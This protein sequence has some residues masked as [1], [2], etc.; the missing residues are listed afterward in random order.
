MVDPGWREVL[1]PVL[2]V[3]QDIN[4]RLFGRE[5]LPE[6]KHVLRVF[7]QPFADV[8]VLLIGQDPYPKPGLAVGLSFSVA[9]DTVPLPPSLQRLLA[10]YERDLG[11]PPPATGDLS[12]WAERGVCLLNRLLTTAPGKIR[13]HAGIGWERV[14]DRVVSA[15][16]ARDAPLVSLLLGRDAQAVAPLVARRPVI[17]T[18]H[19]SPRGRS[20]H[21]PFT[22]SSIF[23]RA[24]ELLVSQGGE[25]V[26]WRLP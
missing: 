11:L 24:N 4:S 25:P 21:R 26:D 2:P 1:L 9:Y 15:L 12:V 10:E 6:P 16:A 7:D 19:P 13:A 5:V 18:A 23:S 22:G 17:E 8:R 3:L 20:L 14:T